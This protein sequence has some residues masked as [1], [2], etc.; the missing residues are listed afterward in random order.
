M[1]SLELH[2][3]LVVGGRAREA[4]EREAALLVEGREAL[5]EDEVIDDSLLAQAQRLLHKHV[6]QHVAEVGPLLRPRLQQV[7]E[8]VLPL[9]GARVRPLPVRRRRE[10]LRHHALAD[11][12]PLAALVRQPVVI[13][14]LEEAQA[15]AEEVRGAVERAAVEELHGHVEPVAL[16]AVAGRALLHRHAEVAELED[17]VLREQQVRR[18]HVHVHP[19]LGVHVVQRRARV[20]GQAP[21]RPLRQRL[22]ER[23]HEVLQRAARAELVL[24]E[25]VE[26][27]LPGHA[28]AHDVR[29]RADGAQRAHL[30]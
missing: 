13:A 26:V 2:G 21:E 12:V 29:V 10:H 23:L 9:L 7:H 3:I 20:A 15:E 28:H 14:H 27:L 24:R 19:P 18:L 8:E 1:R 4:R 5:H 30:A 22:G 25:E 16:G 11:V 6:R 17:A